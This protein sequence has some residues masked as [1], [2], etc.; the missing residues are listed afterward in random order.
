MYAKLQAYQPGRHCETTMLGALLHSV[1]CSISEPMLFGLGQ[2]LDFDFAHDP[3]PESQSVMITGRNGPQELVTNACAALRIDPL[4]TQ[5]TDE[6]EA[7][8]DLVTLVRAGTVV[9]VSVDIFYLDYFASKSHFS[10]HCIAVEAIDDQVAYVI[11]T[12]QQGGRQQLPVTS[13]RRARSSNIG[14]K[15]SPQWS[16]HVEA[17]AEPIG[18]TRLVEPAWYAL[19]ATCRR[20]LST[21]GPDRGLRG[22]RTAAAYF[23]SVPYTLDEAARQ[24]E[25]ARFWR[26]AGTG[27]SNFRTL[28]TQ[29]LT[30]LHLLSEDPLLLQPISEFTQVQRLWDEAIDTLLAVDPASAPASSADVLPDFLSSLATAEDRAFGHLLEVAVTHLAAAAAR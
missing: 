11:D 16:V 28:F 6:D 8:K 2:G 29:F 13:L 30:E 27:G 23:A 3:R 17:A 18:C 24:A 4:T 14:Y 25:L 7:H 20:M 26:F 12:A 9:G 1:R 19:G 5:V 22:M 15:P 21:R 10:A